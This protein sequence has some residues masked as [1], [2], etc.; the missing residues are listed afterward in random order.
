MATPR[1]GRSPARRRTRG[2]RR[3]SGSHGSVSCGRAMSARACWQPAKPK[4]VAITSGH[5][6]THQEADNVYGVHGVRDIERKLPGARRAQAWR[7]ALRLAWRL[8]TQSSGEPG[9]VFSVHAPDRESTA[10]SKPGNPHEFG[11]K[12]TIVTTAQEQ[13]VLGA[14]ALH[15]RPLRRAHAGFVDRASGAR[16]APQRLPRHM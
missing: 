8:L 11:Q 7:N 14:L 3:M 6:Q 5:P 1:P 15:Q 13:S 12:V 10:K 2:S 4:R 16:P 9:K